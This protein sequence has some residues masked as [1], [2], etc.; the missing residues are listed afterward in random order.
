MGLLNRNEIS[1]EDLK[2][3]AQQMENFKSTNVKC[4]KLD[5]TNLSLSE[6][7]FESIQ[8]KIEISKIL[9]NQTQVKN[10]SLKFEALVEKTNY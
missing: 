7:N 2:T 8:D 1:F 9:E 4:L 3:I 6:K 10:L 5:F